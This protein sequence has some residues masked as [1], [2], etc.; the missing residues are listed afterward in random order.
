MPQG[1]TSLLT[2]ASIANTLGTNLSNINSQM[3][4]VGLNIHSY[5]C[6]VS[7]VPSPTAWE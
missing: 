2:A 1:G 3:M 4:M 5:K 7:L 6:L